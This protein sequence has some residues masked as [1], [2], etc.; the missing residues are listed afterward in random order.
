[1][2][3]DDS[4]FALLL[5]ACNKQQIKTLDE[6]MREIIANTNPDEALQVLGQPSR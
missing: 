3:S 6:F 4:R 1:M 2:R 5:V